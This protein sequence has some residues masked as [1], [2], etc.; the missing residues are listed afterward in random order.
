MF[1]SCHFASIAA[2]RTLPTPRYVAVVGC[3]SLNPMVKR[4]AN[5]P[6]G[7]HGAS[8]PTSPGRRTFHHLLRPASED[9][10]Q[11]WALRTKVQG[12]PSI[13]LRP[14]RRPLSHDTVPALP[15]H[16]GQPLNIRHIRRHLRP[17]VMIINLIK[18][19]PSGRLCA[20]NHDPYRDS[21]PSIAV[22][23]D[24]EGRSSPSS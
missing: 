6:F 21:P 9:G 15:P 17:R 14:H 19:S 5:A 11:A 2:F 10:G 4:R 20:P 1:I 7:I 16:Q 22:L 18:T 23:Q 12:I 8:P 13:R 3:R 24:L